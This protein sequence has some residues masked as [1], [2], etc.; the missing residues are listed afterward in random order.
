MNKQL[1]RMEE[2]NRES[3]T[4]IR[5]GVYNIVNSLRHIKI[6]EMTGNEAHIVDQLIRTLEYFEDTRYYQLK[7]RRK[8]LSSE[9]TIRKLK[10]KIRETG[11]EEST[12]PQGFFDI[13]K[14]AEEEK[15]GNPQ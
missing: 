13:E 7:L 14:G 5:L 3:L 6:H 11:Q 9:A 12:F 10:R 8:I 4:L 2:L 1:N 15:L